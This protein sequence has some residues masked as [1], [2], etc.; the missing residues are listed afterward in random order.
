MSVMQG[1]FKFDNL[2]LK[3]HKCSLPFKEFNI[4]SNL[5]LAN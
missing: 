2:V 1:Q 3:P 4:F 5:R